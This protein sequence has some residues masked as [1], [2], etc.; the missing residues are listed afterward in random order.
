[1]S[2]APSP[3]TS[4]AYG[5]SSFVW[6]NPHQADTSASLH[7]LA[8]VLAGDKDIGHM[9]PIPE[10]TMQLFDECR[11]ASA[12]SFIEPRRNAES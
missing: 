12:G 9:L 6:L 10:H 5:H 8:Q 3:P 11:G 4:T 2:A 7:V 1:M